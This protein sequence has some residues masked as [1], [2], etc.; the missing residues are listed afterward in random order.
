MTAGSGV[1]RMSSETTFVSTTIMAA[2]SFE[3]GQWT[4]RTALGKLEFD[5]AERREPSVNRATEILRGRRLADGA[6]QD[7]ARFLLHGAPILGCTYAE[8]TLQSVVEVSDC[9]ARH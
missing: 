1:S 7:I 2:R 9:D 5:T 3:L 4:H 8:P 6:P